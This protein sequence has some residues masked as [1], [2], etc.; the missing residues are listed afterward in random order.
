MIES[1]I[2]LMFF[3]ILGVLA[4]VI[5]H[6]NAYEEF[7]SQCFNIIHSKLMHPQTIFHCSMITINEVTQ[8]PKHLYFVT[9]RVYEITEETLLKVRLMDKKLKWLKIEQLKKESTFS[10]YL[11][12]FLSI[13]FLH[14]I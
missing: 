2:F 7:I 4:V 5:L 1:I 13:L 14:S 12:S 11:S 10:S 3:T 6:M 9:V 8:V